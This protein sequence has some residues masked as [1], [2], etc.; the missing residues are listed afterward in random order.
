MV[1]ITEAGQDN[2]GD[3]LGFGMEKELGKLMPVSTAERMEID[4]VG[5]VGSMQGTVAKFCVVT[6]NVKDEDNI[7]RIICAIENFSSQTNMVCATHWVVADVLLAL[8]KK[9]DLLLE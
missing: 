3:V 9:Q 2:A 4:F 5:N 8:A 1:D 7:S 6:S